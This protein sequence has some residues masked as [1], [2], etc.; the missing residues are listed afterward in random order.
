MDSLKY[1]LAYGSNLDIRQM[2]LRCPGAEIAGTAVIEDYELLFK[3]G[4]GYAYLTI[5][6]KNGSTVPAGV[7]KVDEA[8]E[9]ALDYYEGYPDFYYKREIRLPVKGTD[10]K[11]ELKDCFIYIM[12]EQ[13]KLAWP[14][15]SY[16]E[17]CRAGYRD[18]GFDAEFIDAA[19]N[20][21]RK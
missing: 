16:V 17:G 19:L 12:H 8:H 21:S 5:E 4:Y 13:H 10:G 14:S 7:W 9:A 6:R 3:G 20:K 15:E 18:F 1:Y 2:A 11:T